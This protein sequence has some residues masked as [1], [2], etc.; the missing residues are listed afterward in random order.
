MKQGNSI[1]VALLIGAV[2][3]ATLGYIA[4]YSISFF[5]LP[6]ISVV[7]DNESGNKS[8][9]DNN[10][11]PEP[12]ALSLTAHKISIVGEDGKVCMEIIGSS[13]KDA[14]GKAD[15]SGYILFYD[16]KGQITHFLG[17]HDGSMIIKRADS[18]WG[19]EEPRTM[20]YFDE[21][22][23]SNKLRTKQIER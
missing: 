2:I 16:D 13:A 20:F 21:K 14:D 23:F 15:T 4:C 19:I 9:A 12:S 1:L 18:I 10:T 6:G 5:R 7:G 8:D 11:A 17:T 22:A 3:G